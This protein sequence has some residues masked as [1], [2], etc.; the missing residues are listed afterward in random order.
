MGSG[1]R[2]GPGNV[3]LIDCRICTCLLFLSF[4]AKEIRKKVNYFIRKSVIDIKYST[5]WKRKE[6]L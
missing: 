2:K 5:L 3:S 4:R 6:P 1:V